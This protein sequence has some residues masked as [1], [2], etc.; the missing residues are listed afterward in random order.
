MTASEP[1]HHERPGDDR[2]VGGLD[3]ER[4]TFFTDAVVAIAMTLLVIDLRLP[5]WVTQTAT[6]A[7]LR[8]ALD[9]L[10]RPFLAVA[11]SYM[12]IATW[13]YGHHRLV[14]TL[15]TVDPRFIFMN[16]AF[17]AAIVFLPFPTTMI[18]RFVDLP[19]AVIVYA[20][21]NV[22]AGGMLFLMRWRAGHHDL[23]VPGYPDEERR[24][25]QVLAAIGPVGFAVSIPIALVAPVLAAVSWNSL[26]V[27]AIVVR[28]WYRGEEKAGEHRRDAA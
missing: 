3:L 19:T 10:G 13:W 24:K 22:V 15:R 5:E 16:I 17:L 7:D 28:A 27:A 25:R 11:L 4:I 23:F 2:V 21:T 8:R 6:D 1:G 26:W 14:R 9:E 12:V 18:G 20:A